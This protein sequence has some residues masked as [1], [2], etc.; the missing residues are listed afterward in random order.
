VT[1]FDPPKRLAY[2]WKGGSVD[3]PDYGSA[4]DSIV[5]WR[6]TPERNGTR[7]R[8][9]HSGFGPDNAFAYESMSGSW[10]HVLERIEQIAAKLAAK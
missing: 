3:N 2:S 6:L 7:V 1:V 4:L 9:E 8:M 10:S 5:E